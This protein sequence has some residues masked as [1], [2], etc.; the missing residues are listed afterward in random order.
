MKELDKKDTRQERDLY[1]CAEER[2]EKI[3]LILFLFSFV[4][5]MMHSIQNVFNSI[6]PTWSLHERINGIILLGEENG[7]EKV[8]E[9]EQSESDRLIVT[10]SREKSLLSRES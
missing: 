9:T 1:I 6:H 7:V 2:A 10:R 5:L 8:E 3:R 4:V